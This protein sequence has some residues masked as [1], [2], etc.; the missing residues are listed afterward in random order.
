MKMNGP[1]VKACDFFNLDFERLPRTTDQLLEE[2]DRAGVERAVI[3]GQDI[4]F[5]VNASF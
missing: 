3:L 4:Y 5:N 1:I 2:M